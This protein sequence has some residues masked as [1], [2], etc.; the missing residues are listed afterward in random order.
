MQGHPQQGMQQQIGQH[1]NGQHPNAV[2]N[3]HV[4]QPQQM[5]HPNGQQQQFVG[6]LPPNGHAQ[7]QQQQF[8]NNPQQVNNG[9]QNQPPPGQPIGQGHPNAVP[10]HSN[11]QANPQ[12]Q[13][14]QVVNSQQQVHPNG[15]G[16][17]AS[18]QQPSHA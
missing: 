12:F 8:Q 3:G 9:Y 11:N 14:P 13:Q 15:N 18:Q 10:I 1:P 5:Q 16:Q 4:Q 6:Q 17:A 2:P 7:P